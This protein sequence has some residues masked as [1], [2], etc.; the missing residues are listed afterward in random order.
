MQ[1][2]GSSEL[3]TALQTWQALRVR[4][5]NP[6]EDS[7]WE[8]F[9]ID[10]PSGSVYHHPAWL[11]VLEREY[12]QKGEYLVC[13]D[14]NDNVHG[15]LPLLR[16][17]GLPFALKKSTSGRRLSSLPRTP[18]AGPLAVDSQA[19]VALLQEAVRRASK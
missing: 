14:S 5:T 15:I 7:R 16:T 2:K 17:K 19:S 8:A 1:G 9:V 18:M 4:E 11:A 3:V 13:E 12:G 10:H 6:H